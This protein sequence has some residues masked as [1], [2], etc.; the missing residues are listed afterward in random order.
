MTMLI[1]LMNYPRLAFA[2]YPFGVWSNV[3]GEISL[4]VSEV[5]N[6]GGDMVLQRQQP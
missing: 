6:D 3:Q 2:Y 5:F 1:A 4:L